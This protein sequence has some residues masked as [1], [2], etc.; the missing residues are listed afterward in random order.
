MREKGEGEE[1]GEGEG[2]SV[3]VCVCAC[4]CVC[5][6]CVCVHYYYQGRTLVVSWLPGNPPQHL[7]GE[8]LTKREVGML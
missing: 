7:K 4:V 2:L 8:G 6:M 5:I 1:E 3:C